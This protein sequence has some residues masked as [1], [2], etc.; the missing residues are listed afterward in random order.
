M[1]L[2]DPTVHHQVRIELAVVSRMPLNK[3][4]PTDCATA[5]TRISFSCIPK[6]IICLYVQP[7]REMNTWEIVKLICIHI[8]TYCTAW[9]KLY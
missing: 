8:R 7:E 2:H 3:F 6:K 4:H 5:L 9:N 1:N